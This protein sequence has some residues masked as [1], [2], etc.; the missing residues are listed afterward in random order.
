MP[1]AESR[2]ADANGG[3]EGDRYTDGHP[4]SYVEPVVPRQR[5]LGRVRGDPGDE[6]RPAVAQL[7]LVRRPRG[8]PPTRSVRGYDFAPLLAGLRPVVAGADLAICH[9]ESAARFDPGPFANYPRF[10]VPPQVVRA[11][12][13]TGYDVCTTASNH[14]VDHGFRG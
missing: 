10:S 7:V 4:C 14:S 8:C 6:R 9:L 1:T 5:R 3:R 11:I 2:P 13:A 12:K